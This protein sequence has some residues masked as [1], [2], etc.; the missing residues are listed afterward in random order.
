MNMGIKALEIEGRGR[1]SK[2]AIQ[3]PTPLELF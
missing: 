2:S 1:L 3:Q